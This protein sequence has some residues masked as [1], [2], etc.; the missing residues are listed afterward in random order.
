[1]CLIIWPILETDPGCH[2]QCLRPTAVWG[3]TL[4]LQPPKGNRGDGLL[5]PWLMDTAVRLCSQS[6]RIHCCPWNPSHC[7]GEFYALVLIEPFEALLLNITSDSQMPLAIQT[8]KLNESTVMFCLTARSSAG[9]SW[10]T[11]KGRRAEGSWETSE[12]EAPPDHV[13]PWEPLSAWSLF[14]ARADR[15]GGWGTKG[16]RGNHKSRFHMS[17]IC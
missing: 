12:E 4:S 8:S 9:V 1:M 10:R 2:C 7:R 3:W 5:S 15:T 11:V 14:P 16:C 13:G 6:L 17:S